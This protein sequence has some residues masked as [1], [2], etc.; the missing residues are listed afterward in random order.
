MGRGLLKSL[1]FW[2]SKINY[3]EFM[4]LSYLAKLRHH[5][6]MPIPK[7]QS[8]INFLRTLVALVILR[9]AAFALWY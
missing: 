8:Y 4:R 5:S 1:R 2:S 7:L 3:Y 9:V 6:H